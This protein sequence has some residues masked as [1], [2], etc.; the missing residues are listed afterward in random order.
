MLYKGAKYL[1][2]DGRKLRRLW[3]PFSKRR[4]AKVCEGFHGAIEWLGWED[5]E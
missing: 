2:K 3:N 4:C 5:G 1:G